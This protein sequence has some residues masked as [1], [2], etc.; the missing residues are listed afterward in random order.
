MELTL[1]DKRLSNS[2]HAL[3]SKVGSTLL[4]LVSLGANRIRDFLDAIRTQVGDKNE[5]PSG[6]SVT[7]IGLD[8]GGGI[9]PDG[10]GVGGGGGG[11]L[12]LDG[13]VALL[14][15]DAIGVDL[16]LQKLASSEVVAFDRSRLSSEILDTVCGG[17]LHKTTY[18][19]EAI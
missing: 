16:R 19:R 5:G 6:R 2:A 17:P 8:L 1:T 4:G 10:E 12:P 9:G 3:N 7:A 14:S 11:L 18:G 13:A 15:P